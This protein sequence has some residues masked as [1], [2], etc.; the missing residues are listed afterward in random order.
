LVQ[1]FF[2]AE[3]LIQPILP[4]KTPLFRGSE[5]RSL[6]LSLFLAPIN[7]SFSLISF[8]FALFLSPCHSLLSLF[9]SVQ[10]SHFFP[11]L[12]FFLSTYLPP[13]P[14]SCVQQVPHFLVSRTRLF[15]FFSEFISVPSRARFA[16]WTLFLRTFALPCVIRKPR[17]D[18]SLPVF[19]FFLAN[20]GLDFPFSLTTARGMAGSFGYDRC[21]L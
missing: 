2:V 6:A 4:S 15:M 10:A 3:L 18:S 1:N 14:I 20:A 9:F 11:T 12:L 16:L 19:K 17:P 5:N 8:F 7:F 13:G 21:S